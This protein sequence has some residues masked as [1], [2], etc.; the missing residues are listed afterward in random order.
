VSGDYPPRKCCVSTV[1]VPHTAGCP[2][3]ARLDA[4]TEPAIDLDV[5]AMESWFPRYRFE[6]EGRYAS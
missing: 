6:D 3:L 5:L 4:P 1:N 2:K